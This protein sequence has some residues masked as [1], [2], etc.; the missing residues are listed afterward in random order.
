MAIQNASIPVGATY[1]P[2]GGTART[3]KFLGN[4]TNGIKTFIDDSPV[5][6][7][8]RKILYANVR[9]AVPEPSS[10]DGYTHEK[11]KLEFQIPFTNG[12]G[13]VVVDKVIVEV[14]TNVAADATQKALLRGLIANVGSDADFDDFFTN[15][16]VG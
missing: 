10:I 2:T 8:L 1:A 4:V 11:K 3:I 12:A 6:S 9:P 14:W 13:D 7:V 15:G 16:G 5:S